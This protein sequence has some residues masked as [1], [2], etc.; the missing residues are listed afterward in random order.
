MRHQRTR[1]G[2]RFGILAAATALAA[3]AVVVPQYAQAGP[4]Q[5][6]A[7]DDSY[8]RGPDPTE[9]SITAERGP[10]AVS[11]QAVDGPGFNRGTA[12]YPTD[13][14]QGTFGA[15][16]VSPG[17]LT[18]ESLISWYGPRFASQGF[19]VLTLETDSVT[20]QPDSRA[21]QMLAALDYLATSSAVKNRIDPGRLAV[22]GHSM[23]GGGSLRASE[24]R[25]ALQAA[26]PLMPWENDKTWESNRV[27]TL[28]MGAENDLI[29]SPGSHSERFY[30]TLT[31]A[32]EK[33]YLE[34]NGAGHNVALSANTTIAKYGIAWL[35][36][37]VDDDTRYEKFLC[38]APRPDGNINEYRDTCPTG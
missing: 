24:Q 4:D 25:P 11:R 3:A 12:Y 5:Q 9:Q 8:Q 1:T 35:K 17:F 36:R 16:V 21:R 20:D 23:G 33:A 32:P 13:T 37:F 22:M 7:A 10:F 27:P 18:S 14:S 31:S 6:A 38:P 19:V 29:A 15:V 30:G 26:V 34:L 2:K 28:I